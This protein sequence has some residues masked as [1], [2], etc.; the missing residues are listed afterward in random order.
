WG[1]LRSAQS[2]NLGRIVLVDTD[3]SHED[4]AGLAGLAGLVGLG[5]PQV[6][7]RSGG[8]FVPR[9]ARAAGGELT[10][11]PGVGCWSLR[12]SGKGTLEDLA[13][14]PA[15]AV[16]AGAL[17]EGQVRVAVRAA[18]VN[19]RD[20]LNALGMY[21]GEVPLGAEGAGVVLEVG[22]G[23][24]G[25]RPGDRVMG[26]FSGSFANEAVTDHR[27][28]T[29]IPD[30]WSY[31]EA[32][33]V[34]AAFLTAYYGLVDLGGLRAGES[35]LVHAA[36]GGVG[37]AAVQLARHLGA[38]VFATASPAKWP[39]LRDLG[40]PAGRI[41]SS[42]NLDFAAAFTPVDVVLNSLAGEY[43]DASL[44][45]LA[46]GGRFLEMGRTDIRDP[47]QLTTP[48]PDIVYSPF[49]LL[50]AGLDRIQAMLRELTALFSQGV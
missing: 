1:L 37:T 30:H 15:P 49:E 22:A 12:G 24:S 20:V 48:H 38:E 6:A 9:L 23:V 13:L 25:L 33:A 27:A 16:V 36:T 10:V 11:P 21:P 3:G 7:V 40:I 19:F 39:V 32:A 8:V 17:P 45:L 42:R 5:E 14:L 29:T 50:D 26:L 41:A 2:E 34:P 47:E 18:G 35:V 4:V 46:A 44:G 43:V 31:T 28:L